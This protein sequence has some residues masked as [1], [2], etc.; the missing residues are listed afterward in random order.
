MADPNMVRQEDLR[1]VTKLSMDLGTIPVGSGQK[2][3]AVFYD[4]FTAKI[5]H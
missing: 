2:A 5:P 3:P 4:F 1:A